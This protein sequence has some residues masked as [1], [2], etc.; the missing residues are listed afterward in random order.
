[1]TR[2]ELFRAALLSGVSTAALKSQV[3]RRNPAFPG[4]KFRPYS[5]CLPDHLSNLAAEAVRRRN[6]ELAKLTSP[7]SIHARQKWARE[8]LW[9]LIGGLEEKTPLNPRVVGTIDRDNYRIEKVVYESQP[10][11]FVPA[12]LYIP[13]Q[14]SGPYPAVLFQSGHYWEGK[15]Y[16]SYQR[17]CQGLVQ[18]GFV[19]LAFEPMGQGERIN[20]LDSSGKHSRLQSPDAE[21]TVPGKQLILFGDSTTR[22]QLWDAVRSLDYL[23]SLPIVDAKRMA[24]VGHSGGATLTML[25]AAGDERLAAAAVCM[26][27]TENVAALPFHPPGATDDAEQDF[28][29]SGPAGFDR[30]DLFYP[31][32]PKPMLIWP[33][34]RDFLATYSS[35]Y[36]RNGWEEYQKLKRVYEQLD[37]ADHLGWADTPLPHALAYDS[38]LLIYSWFTRWL[39]D[40][41]HRVEQEPPVKPEPVSD[42]WATEGGSVIRSLNST[43]PF[44]LIKSRKVSRTPASLESLL[45][46]KRPSADTRATTIGQVESRTVR[47]EILEVPSAPGVWLPAFLMVPDQTPK[48]KPTLL[49][50]EEESSDRL[51]FNPEVDL[52]L[53]E[54]GPIVCSADVRGVGTLV[55]EFSPGQAGYAAWHQQEENYAWGSLILGEPLVGQRVTD[56]L[57]LTAALRQHP[58]TAGRPLHIAAQGKLTVPALFAA[59]IDP[60]IKGLFLAEGLVSFQNVT[61]TEVYT[62]PF[63]NFIPNLLTHTDLPEIVA[64]MSPR[65]VTLAGPVDASGASMSLDSARNIYAASQSSGHLTIRSKTEWSTEALLS[66]LEHSAS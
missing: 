58:R 38:R 10:N 42:L 14:G 46:V 3:T 37:H 31:F 21:H 63:A 15:A 65:R 47:V 54:A 51:W 5:R 13:K 23:A 1:M 29:Y 44:H 36:I 66:Y 41:T 49:V 62:H 52:V 43:T 39:K 18:L 32:A 7:A 22:L 35:E 33:S 45:K 2:R 50:L 28:V 6:A 27:N 55:P 12:N 24:S 9:N 17:C 60:D 8:T 40:E 61:E 64:S 53:P 4:T 19:V 30:W 34:D 20:Y 48:N 26:G 11:L 56:I 59:A 57:A 16:P 25:L